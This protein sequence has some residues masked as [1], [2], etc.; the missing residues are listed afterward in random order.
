MAKLITELV[1]AQRG[2][3]ERAR[4]GLNTVLFPDC[5]DAHLPL[6]R[7]QDASNSRR[8][9]KIIGILSRRDI[10]HETRENLITYC[11]GLPPGEGAEGANRGV[12]T[13][14]EHHDTCHHGD[15]SS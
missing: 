6:P 10:K 2:K 5:S 3:G 12:V 11:R 1:A 13:D 7:G 15:L 14:R 4:G 9:E 8:C